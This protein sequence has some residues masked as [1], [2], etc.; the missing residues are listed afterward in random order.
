MEGPDGN[1]ISQQIL[2]IALVAIQGNSEHIHPI[3][4]GVV[5]GLY[6]VRLHALVFIN[7]RPAS[8]VGHDASSWGSALRRAIGVP[9][10]TRIPNEVAPRNGQRVGAVAYYVTRVVVV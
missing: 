4:D 7:G 8:F 5:K 1:A 9:N 10:E 6:D 2:R 3:I